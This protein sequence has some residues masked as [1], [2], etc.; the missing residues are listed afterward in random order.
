MSVLLLL[1]L[2]VIWM[3]GGP[4]S[5]AAGRAVPLE[6]WGPWL[7]LFGYGVLI[8]ALAVRDRRLVRRASR[9][10]LFVDQLQ[11]GGW[12]LVT[13]QLLIPLWLWI[14]LNYL[15]WSATVASMLG[16]VARWQ[17]ESPGLL[18][19]VLPALLAWVGLWWAHYPVYRALRERH[20]LFELDAQLPIYAP[21]TLAEY[22]TSRL[23]MQLLFTA[24]P[25]LLIVAA[26]DAG[27]L[28]LTRLH[29]LRSAAAA[30]VVV[31]A[32]AALLVYITAPEVL[33]RVLATEPLPDEPLRQQLRAV[34]DRDGVRCR[35]VLL[36]RTH[37][38]VGNAA[39]MG[40]VRRF[41]YVLL[42]DLLLESLPDEQVLAVFAHELGHVVH[43]H[44][45][46]YGVFL[47]GLSLAFVG[48]G[49]AVES[50]AHW[51]GLTQATID[52][53]L[54]IASMLLF[55]LGFGFVS[56]RFE[57]QADVH[58]ARTMQ[59][60][61]DVALLSSD[62]ADP[63]VPAAIPDRTH[64]G[65]AGAAAFNSALRRIS[66]VNHI[67]LGVQGTFAGSLRQRAR[68][69]IEWNLRLAGSWLHGTMLTRMNYINRISVDPALTATFD[70]QMRRLRLAIVLMLI[71]C[72]A[73]AASSISRSAQANRADD[74]STQA[75]LPHTLVLQIAQ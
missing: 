15:G 63:L 61:A 42:S 49:D 57:R 56:R 2:F 28:L 12:G 18:L 4:D 45:I 11:R 69:L 35:E 47:I 75:S 10:D 20:L 17:L 44:M 5:A 60:L 58:A 52:Q 53:I 33:R 46:W 37:H 1:L 21:P 64:V 19:G 40:I 25:V 6:G 54:P 30:D 13:A 68:Y 66:A 31:S 32:G 73:W 14:G 3:S 70:R 48:L 29:L 27:G 7:F 43:R 24:V 38:S 36:W 59:A 65:P 62:A 16:P 72:A 22:V 34:A 9:D 67:P 74:Q 41:R 26:R 8:V 55:V 39:V 71:A 23:R 51:L 50:V